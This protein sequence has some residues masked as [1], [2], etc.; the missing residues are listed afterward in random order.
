[1]AGWILLNSLLVRWDPYPYILLN[2]GLSMIA[3]LQG[4]ILLIAA[5]RQDQIAAA[6]ARND[7]DTNIA[8]RR[9]V[10]RLIAY[11]ER[12]EAV[13]QALA[14]RVKDADKRTWHPSHVRTRGVTRRRP[15]LSGEPSG[16]TLKRV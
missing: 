2:L 13:V 10:E 11:A 16:S 3:G 5:K 9:D 1:M 6:L 7:Y 15:R 4:A 12:Q 14:K 8:A